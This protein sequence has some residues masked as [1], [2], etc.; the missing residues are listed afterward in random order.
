M[1]DAGVKKLQ[2]AL[3]KLQ[4]QALKR[5]IPKSSP[6]PGMKT[7]LWLHS[8]MQFLAWSQEQLTSVHGSTS[9][10]HRLPLSL[11]RSLP[12]GNRRL[13]RFHRPLDPP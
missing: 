8:S 11:Q 4:D 10:P 6:R 3:P 12:L 13:L 1:T 5:I 2:Q 7:L 9:R